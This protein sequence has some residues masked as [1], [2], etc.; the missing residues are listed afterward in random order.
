MLL[1]PHGAGIDVHV[2]VNLNGGHLETG[3]LEEEAGGRG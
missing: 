2:G 1:W 3:G